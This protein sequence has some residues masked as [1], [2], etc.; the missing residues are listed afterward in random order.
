MMYGGDERNLL[1]LP[2]GLNGAIEQDT[3]H[4]WGPLMEAG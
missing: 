1:S 4:R 3:C 2:L